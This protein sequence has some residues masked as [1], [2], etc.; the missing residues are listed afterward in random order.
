MEVLPKL[1]VLPTVEVL[2]F[3]GCV[4][5]GAASY[6]L[7]TVHQEYFQNWRLIVEL[8]ASEADLGRKCDFKWATDLSAVSLPER[9]RKRLGSPSQVREFRASNEEQG[10]S[11]LAG[12]GELQDTSDLGIGIDFDI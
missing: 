8:H 2:A 9:I 6:S 11:A 1:E 10:D 12:N 7:V 3:L 4:S 5:V